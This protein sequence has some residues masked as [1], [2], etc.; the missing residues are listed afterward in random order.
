MQPQIQ[1]QRVRRTLIDKLL[2]WRHA[3]QTRVFDSQREVVGRAPTAEASRD[4]AMA[5]WVSQGQA[6]YEA[7]EE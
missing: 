4:A 1:T 7:A 6:E 2:L 5:K 3:Y